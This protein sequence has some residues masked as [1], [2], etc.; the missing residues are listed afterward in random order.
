MLTMNDF[1]RIGE[2][3]LLSKTRQLTDEERKELTTLIAL[4]AVMHAVLHGGT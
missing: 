2:L 4:Q 3:M 1:K